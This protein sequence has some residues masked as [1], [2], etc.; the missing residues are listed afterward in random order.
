MDSTQMVISASSTHYHGPT[1][2]EEGTKGNLFLPKETISAMALALCDDNK[3]Q[4][5]RLIIHQS[6]LVFFSYDFHH[7]HTLIFYIILKH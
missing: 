1:I 7:I 5:N 4:S 6:A 3:Y 2:L